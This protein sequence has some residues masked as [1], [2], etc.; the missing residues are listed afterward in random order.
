[1]NAAQSILTGCLRV[2]R[3]TVSPFLS[4]LC[5]PGS[6]CRFQ[7]TCSEYAMEAVRTHGAAAG[8]WLALRRVCRC[9]PWGACGSDPVPT[10]RDR[11]TSAVKAV[12]PVA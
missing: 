6:G 4:F 9:H 11:T 10:P 5:G 12:N 3:W 8:S 2:Y 7:P 1:M